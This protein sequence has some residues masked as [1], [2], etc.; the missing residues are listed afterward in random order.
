MGPG[1]IDSVFD[2]PSP[3]CAACQWQGQS[4]PLP[5]PFSFMRLGSRGWRSQS[6]TVDLTTPKWTRPDAEDRQPEADFAVDV[7]VHIHTRM[8]VCMYMHACMYVCIYVLYVCMHRM[9]YVCTHTHTH[10]HTHLL[11]PRIPSLHPLRYRRRRGMAPCCGCGGGLN[12]CSRRRGKAGSG[13]VVSFALDVCVCVCVCVCIAPLDLPAL[14]CSDFRTLH[15][16]YSTW[17]LKTLNVQF[18]R[19][20]MCAHV[21]SLGKKRPMQMGKETY[22]Y[23]KWDPVHSL[24][25]K[26]HAVMVGR[27]GIHHHMPQNS[28]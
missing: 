18:P 23:R 22:L 9:Q 12:R 14:G 19:Q 11:M 28:R 26:R 13:G 3:H 7:E 1:G 17:S 8:H 4:L 15:G 2:L 27:N 24:G 25:K 5:G 6:A 20:N 16:T 10:T 21:H